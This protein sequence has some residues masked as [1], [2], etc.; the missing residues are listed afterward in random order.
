MPALVSSKAARQTQFVQRNST[1]MCFL[2]LLITDDAA[3]Q[4]KTTQAVLSVLSTREKKGTA[5]VVPVALVAAAIGVA[6][7]A[8]P[9]GEQTQMMQ[10]NSAR[11][12][13]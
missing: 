1:R 13:K 2:Q 4:H 11:Q 6:A 12:H 7:P 5:T 10:H 9:G 3:E 8:G